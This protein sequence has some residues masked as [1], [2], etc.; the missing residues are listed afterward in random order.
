MTRPEILTDNSLLAA[1]TACGQ[2]LQRHLQPVDLHQGQVLSEPSRPQHFAYFPTS[3]IVSLLYLT[4]NGASTEVAVVGR[5]GIV[6]T[7]LLLGGRATTWQASV[8]IGGQALCIGAQALTD[9]FERSDAVRQV[10]LRYTQA[11]AAQIAQTA[12]CNRH[13]AIEQQLCGWLLHGLDRLRGDEVVVTHELI[14][15]MLGVRRESVTQATHHL[16]AAGLILCTRGH[17]VVLDRAG[18]EQRACGCHAVVKKEYGRLLPPQPAARRAEAGRPLW[19]AS[20]QP[21]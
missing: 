20:V 18:L 4:E 19:P 17:I 6:G 8:L 7:A 5:E 21:A 9:A 2:S 1:L 14:A 15:S 12:V 16:Q 3:A 13:H 11:L 10:V